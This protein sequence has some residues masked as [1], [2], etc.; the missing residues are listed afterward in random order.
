MFELISYTLLTQLKITS[1]PNFNNQNRHHYGDFNEYFGAWHLPNKTFVHKKSC[2][3]VTYIT[4]SYGAI[5]KERNIYG[6]NRTIVIGD[7][8]VEGFGLEQKNRFSNI[9]EDELNIPHLNFGT[10]GHFGSTQYKLLYEN[11]ASKFEHSRVL[12]FIT[13]ANDFEDDSY[14]F[15]KKIHNNRYRPYLIKSGEEYNL[16]Y[17]NELKKSFS[18][19]E[20]LKN[21]FNNFTHTY[22]VLKYLKSIITSENI[23]TANKEVLSNKN[24][25]R[26][27]FYNVYTDEGF[28]LMKYNILGIQKLS[29]K[30]N[31]KLSVILLPYKPDIDI[32][33]E[34]Q[35][36]FPKLTK[37]FKEFSNNNNIEFIDI[38]TSLNF[39]KF[40]SED[41]FFEC[42]GHYNILANKLIADIIK[43]EIYEKN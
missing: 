10:A 14:A 35:K 4:N 9:I 12:L 6:K 34:N 1:R 17:T 36:Q 27:S 43:D 28:D 21:F 29:K 33:I 16:I 41:L 18:I 8:M 37:K 39:S 31:A 11:L 7:S 3:D 24:V 20:N 2:F 5:D 22:H 19:F 32:Y 15:G 30:N 13:V 23:K 26:Y 38:L 25:H 42:D 40:K